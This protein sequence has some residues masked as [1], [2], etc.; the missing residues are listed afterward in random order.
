MRGRE[1]GRERGWEGRQIDFLCYIEASKPLPCAFLLALGRAEGEVEESQGHLEENFH[2]LKEE[3]VPH[4][5]HRWP[6]QG[7]G[8]QDMLNHSSIPIAPYETEKWQR[9]P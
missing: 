2:P 8:G 4:S 5:Q 7:S 1:G 6:G 9:T 3:H